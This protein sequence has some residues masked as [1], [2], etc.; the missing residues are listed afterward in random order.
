[1]IHRFSPWVL[2]LGFLFTSTLFSPDARAEQTEGFRECTENCYIKE[3][4][5]VGL[6][7]PTVTQKQMYRRKCNGHCQEKMRRQEDER[8]RARVREQIALEDANAA[9]ARQNL[10]HKHRLWMER[11]QLVHKL[12]HEVEQARQQQKTKAQLR[13]LQRKMKSAFALQIEALREK[14]EQ[15]EQFLQAR[16]KAREHQWRHAIDE[17]KSLRSE[18]ARTKQQEPEKAREIQEQIQKQEKDLKENKQKANVLQVQYLETKVESGQQGVKEIEAK[19]QVVV[20]EK[21]EAEE[22]KDEQRLQELARRLGEMAGKQAAMMKQVK[23]DQQQLDKAKVTLT[24]APS[25]DDEK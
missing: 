3:C 11:Q 9:R 23:K 12:K 5:E 10:E 24:S 8:R 13:A 20:D 15:K 18:L 21:K 17:I 22:Q 2:S 25:Q 6:L 16:T 1:M 14:L 4:G 7:C 19:K